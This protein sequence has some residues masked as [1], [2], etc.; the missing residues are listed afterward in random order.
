MMFH[1]F[2]MGQPVGYRTPRGLYVTEGT[3]IVTALLPERNGAFVRASIGP[4][5]S[6]Q[7]AAMA[8]ATWHP[9]GTSAV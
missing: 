4:N 3:F 8:A 5:S 2:K 6:D 7:P 1:K 9:D